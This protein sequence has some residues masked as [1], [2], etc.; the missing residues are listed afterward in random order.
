LHGKAERA[1]LGLSSSVRNRRMQR[2]LCMGMGGTSTAYLAQVDA[3][4]MRIVTLLAEESKHPD[5]HIRG[6]LNTE[7]WLFIPGGACS[8]LKSGAPG[9]SSAGQ[10]KKLPVGVGICPVWAHTGRCRF[11]DGP[12][13]CAFAHPNKF[14]SGAG[15]KPNDRKDHGKQRWQDRRND[16]KPSQDKDKDR[17]K[18]K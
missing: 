14:A 5:D 8:D 16:K 10:G 15:D 11:K 13:G 12:D 3:I 6:L 7:P 2:V 1:R 4:L 9:P 18:D 17:N